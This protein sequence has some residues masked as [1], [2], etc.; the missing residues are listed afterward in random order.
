ML[1]C[2][3]HSRPRIDAD[4]NEVPRPRSVDLALH[5]LG[6][7]VR[8]DRDPAPRWPRSWSRRERDDAALDWRPL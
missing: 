5:R 2:I 1:M 3:D 8:P 4:T 7:A 6:F